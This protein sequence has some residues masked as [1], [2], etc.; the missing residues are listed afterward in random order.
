M[1]TIQALVGF[2]LTIRLIKPNC[3]GLGYLVT[4]TLS[5]KHI[6]CEFNRCNTLRVIWITPLALPPNNFRLSNNFQK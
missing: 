3:M 5:T 2:N 1:I 4:V 6:I